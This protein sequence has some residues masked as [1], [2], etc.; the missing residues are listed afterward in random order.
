MQNHPFTHQILS[1]Y[2]QNRRDLPWRRTKSPYAIWLSEII[3]QQT[4]IQQGTSYWFKFMEAFPDVESL[5]AASED[6]V[7]RL[8]QGLGY[9]SRARNLLTA[10]RQIVA[11]G[12]FPNTIESLQKLKGVGEYTAA[13]IG[14][15]AFDLPVACVDGNVYR[16]LS[17]VFGIET[18]I[19]TTQG[20]K[21]FFAVAQS[22]VPEKQSADFNQAMMDFGSLQCV[23]HAPVCDVCPLQ[24]I[25]EAYRS[26]RVELLP[27]KNKLKHIKTRHLIYYYIR[28]NGKTAIHRRA[29]GDIWQGLWELVLVEQ[30]DDLKFSGTITP[31]CNNVKHILTHQRLFA[32]LYLVETTQRPT[33][34]DDYQWVDET[35]L[36]NFALPRLIEILLERLQ[37]HD[38][39]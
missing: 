12:S 2:A 11:L 1:W 32:D 15:F 10:A 24:T 19:N 34:P 35:A 27:V 18:P 3:L 14:S 38:E 29:K 28:C 5:A 23:P 8:W 20:K 37:Q 33:L 36:S 22:L 26:S 17:R 16:I 39:L 30:L 7:L 13:A 25:C 6:D 9:Y 4:R 31:I 21:E